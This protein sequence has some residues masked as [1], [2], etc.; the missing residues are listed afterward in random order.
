PERG[1]VPPDEFMLVANETGLIVPLGRQ[2]LNQACAQVHRWQMEYATARDLFIAINLSAREFQQP[3][4]V[5]TLTRT[6][7]QHGLQPTQVRLEVDEAVIAADPSS[8]FDKLYRLRQHGIQLAIDDFGTGYS[9]LSYLTRVTFDVLKI[10]R[11]FISGPG[12]ITNNLSIVRAV[13]SLAHALGMAVTAEGI[14]TR[15]H[16]T[17][18]RAAGC[19]YG[20]GF[21]FSE[22]LEPNDVEAMLFAADNDE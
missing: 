15:E 22:P 13:T 12:G 1:E 19:D 11:G 7:T 10:A 21:L 6:I 8:A 2:I 16:L 14:E 3:D 5:E 17:R 4:A 18:V 20:Q 9:S